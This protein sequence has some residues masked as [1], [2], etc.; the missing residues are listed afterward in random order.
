MGKE[1]N[2]PGSAGTI[3]YLT[4][5][6]G[7]TGSHVT[8]S[9]G[10]LHTA[11]Q[12]LGDRNDLY[13]QISSEKRKYILCFKVSKRFHQKV[14]MRQLFFFFSLKCH[15]NGRIPTTVFVCKRGGRG[16]IPLIA[17]RCEPQPGAVQPSGRVRSELPLCVSL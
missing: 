1:W 17:G 12:C 3:L 4:G 5:S 16:L 11:A 15:G 9:G 13:F 8:L 6:T 10:S 14:L 2:C 7:S